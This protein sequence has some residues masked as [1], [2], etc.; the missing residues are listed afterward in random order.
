M[1]FQV[2]GCETAQVD[3]QN[4]PQSQLALSRGAWH[5]LRHRPELAALGPRTVVF[6][7]M[8]PDD[9]IN[10]TGVSWDS[11]VLFFN[12]IF[13]GFEW[14]FHVFFSGFHRV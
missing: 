3:V 14:D 8:K 9:K 7:Q 13:M 2:F 1:F 4:H 10:A 12:G 6:G 11:H 5:H